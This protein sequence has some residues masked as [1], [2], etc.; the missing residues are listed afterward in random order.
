MQP[1][2]SSSYHRLTS[3]LTS[4]L[5]P[6]SWLRMGSSHYWK[7]H[8]VDQTFKG[9]YRWNAFDICAAGS[10]LHRDGHPRLLRHPS[11][12][13]GLALLRK[14]RKKPRSRTNRRSASRGRA[15][16]RHHPAPH[17]QRAVRH[18]PPDRRLLPP[19]LSARPLRDPGARRLHRRDHD[20]RRSRSSS[21]TPQGFAASAA[22]HRLH[23]PHQS[24]RLQG[25][26]S[27]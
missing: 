6:C 26:R 27:R 4:A 12:S 19:R 8:Y 24:P 20:G 18:R 10:L 3:S 13:A 25:R 5:G 17:L 9:L 22:A 15:A 23:P 14:N 7:T 21:A 1:A 2:R 16:L 11:L